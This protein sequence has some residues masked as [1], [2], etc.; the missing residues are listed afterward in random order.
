MLVNELFYNLSLLPHPIIKA[1]YLHH[2]LIRIHPFLDGNG[3]VTRIAK[4]WILMYDLYPP[5]FI[6]DKTE[7]AEYIQT[8]GNSFKVIAKNPYEW[9]EFTA[10][11]FEQELD[12]LLAN[13]KQ[14]FEKVNEL[15]LQHVCQKQ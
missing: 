9:N 6:N 3:R 2:E 5:I 10:Q 11:F 14:M 12:R 4:N 15:G 7:K 8:L 13:A 1:I